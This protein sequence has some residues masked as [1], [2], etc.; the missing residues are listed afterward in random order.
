[1]KQ[2]QATLKTQGQ[3]IG[4]DLFGVTELNDLMEHEL[5]IDNTILDGYSRA[6][7][8]GIVIPK[9]LMQQLLTQNNISSNLYDQFLDHTILPMLDRAALFMTL[10]LEKK[11]FHA[12]PLP[13]KLSQ[14]APQTP[15]YFHDLMAS[16]AGIG[17]LG[18]NNALV[19]KSY[20]TRI[21]C[22]TII[23]DAPLPA[24]TPVASQCDQCTLC[25]EQ[26]PAQALSGIP[27]HPLHHPDVRRDSQK[28]LS[29][30]SGSCGKCLAV[31]PFNQA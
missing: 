20:G 8:I 11:G 17:W 16:Y 19:S 15:Y 24:D 28:C 22:T 21:R 5:T 25:I 31:C 3:L 12:L 27:F 30:G 13:A 26:C 18:K 9:S 29:Q 6:L 7:S 2:L 14:W 10:I 1:M 4:V 23:T